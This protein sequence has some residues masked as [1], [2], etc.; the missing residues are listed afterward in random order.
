M[1][2]LELA[3]EEEVLKVTGAPTGFAGPVGL[4]VRVLADYEVRSMVDAITGANEA[5]AHYTG[6]C[7]GRDFTVET[8]ADLRDAVAGDPCPR[9]A[10]K[11]EVWRGIE[12]GHVFKLG[13]K[14]SKKMHATV[15]DAQVE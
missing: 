6:V 15:L 11:L 12:V 13:T 8:F 4:K 10:G 7:C 3:G 14:Y 2:F 1:G 9:C 5:D